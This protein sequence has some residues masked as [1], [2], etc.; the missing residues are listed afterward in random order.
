MRSS[1]P[2]ATRAVEAEV[3]FV[4]CGSVGAAEAMRARRWSISGR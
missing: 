1:S 2:T 4:T 3:T